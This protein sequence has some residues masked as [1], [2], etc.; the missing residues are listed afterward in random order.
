MNWQNEY[1]YN[2]TSDLSKAIIKA[3][4]ANDRVMAKA[5]TAM[6]NSYKRGRY[7]WIDSETG[8]IKM[9]RIVSPVEV[10]KT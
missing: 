1:P 9:A 5:L 2:I 4:N 6:M 7:V 10:V 8:E 3:I